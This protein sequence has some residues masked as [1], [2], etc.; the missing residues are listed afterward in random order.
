MLSFDL[1]FDGFMPHAHSLD[2]V[3]LAALIH[4]ALY[5]EDIRFGGGDDDVHVRTFEGTA[6]GVDDK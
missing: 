4:L 6:R 5:H 3:F 1:H 2:Q